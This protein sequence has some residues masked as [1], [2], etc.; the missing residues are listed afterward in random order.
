MKVLITSAASS[1]AYRLRN[2]L[3][4]YDIILG[5]YAEL[6]ELLLKTGSMLRLPNPADAAYAHKMLTLCLDHHISAIYAVHDAEYQLLCEADV[7]FNEYG[8]TIHPT[9][10]N[11]V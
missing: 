3:I 6:P 7:L 2:N 10:N 4:Q 1:A 8:I 5:D 11:A 9:I